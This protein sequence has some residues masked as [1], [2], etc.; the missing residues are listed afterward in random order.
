MYNEHPLFEAPSPDQ[1]L[2]RYLDFT[3]FVSLLDKASLFFVRADRL[4]DPFEG[5]FSKV[6][7]AIRPE[8]YKGQMSA[9]EIQR[10]AS[11]HRQLPRFTLVS[12]WHGNTHESA[13]M[14]R[15]YA[16]EHDG[17]AVRTDFNSLCECLQGE[18]SVFIGKVNYVDFDST[19][20]PEGNTMAP[21]LYKRIS[22]EHE[23]EVR[24]VI[25][26]IPPVNGVAD[27][28]QPVH[29]NG[30]YHA[31]DL[32]KL[33]HEVVISPFAHDWFLELV[34][35]VVTKYGLNTPVEKS[36]LAD[37]PVWG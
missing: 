8:I 24:A 22:F 7:Q 11:I 31:V 25:Q 35:S 9:E 15:L 16:S 20:I 13:A 6:N 29:E 28:G 14:W 2:W 4:G 18:D 19:F 5:S 34:Q 33:V 30:R 36:P 21:F 1:V 27:V 32:K 23:K 26:D 3:K 12:C 10:F 17:I 37:A